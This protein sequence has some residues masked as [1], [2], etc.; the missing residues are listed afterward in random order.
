MALKEESNFY[1]VEKPYS[2]ESLKSLI[3][4]LI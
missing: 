2:K 3:T 4:K 1:F